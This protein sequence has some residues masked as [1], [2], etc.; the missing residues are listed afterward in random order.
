MRQVVVTGLGIVSAIGLG[1]EEHWRNLVAGRSGERPISVFDASGFP[2]R[3]A[4][5]VPEYDVR[6]YWPEELPDSLLAER[7]T[8]F[9]L[10]AAGMAIADSCLE[11]AGEPAAVILGAGL[12]AVRIEDIAQFLSAE[13]T[14]DYQ[15]FPRE[16]GRIHPESMIRNPP[17]VVAGLIARRLGF[18]GAN[19]S[20]TSA[21]AAGAQA[22]GLAYRQLQ[23][24]DAEIAICG[25]ADSMLNPLG[26]TGFVLLG[27]ASKLNEAGIFSRPFDRTRSGL[28]MGE[29]AGIVVLETLAHARQ[30]RARIY[31]ELIGY[32]TSLDAYHITDPHPQ[33]QGAAQAMRMAI[34]DAGLE[35]Q[36]V[37]YINAHGTSTQ[38]NDK[39]ETLAIKQV[40][41]EHAYTIPIS[42]NKSMI[43]HLIAACGA[44]EFIGTVLTVYHQIIPPT[45]NYH[46]PDPA[47]DLD[48][49]PNL[50]RPC[51]VEVALTNSFG[52]GGQNATL[53]LRR[54][55]PDT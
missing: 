6:R 49:V 14:F 1:H 3:I 42:S 13:G 55:T 51:P 47:C 22:I 8:R 31:A 39:M 19:M 41:G 27:A 36:S 4:A 20:I 25:A 24:G 7:R 43:G 33:G 29:G 9:G 21:C 37:H 23:E 48:Y 54:Y 16:L 12:G 26:L 15:R 11:S 52:L 44:A 30:R 46:N 32:G 17:D 34:R 5:E 53:V 50:A 28:V 18:T 40:F 2:V 10:A 35:P 38:L 45:I